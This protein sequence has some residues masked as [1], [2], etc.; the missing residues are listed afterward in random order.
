MKRIAALF[1]L[2]L[3]AA[4]ALADIALVGCSAEVDCN[5]CT[6][7]EVTAPT[8]SDGDLLAIFAGYSNDLV[9]EQV[10]ETGWTVRANGEGSNGSDRT[11]LVETKVAASESGTYTVETT[12][13]GS[14]NSVGR[15]CAFSGVHADVLDQTSVEGPDTQD[16]DEWD[17][18]AITTQTANAWV[19]AFVVGAGGAQNTFTVPSGYTS[20]IAN[21]TANPIMDA[22]RKLVASAGSEDP[23]IY[24]VVSASRDSSGATL[25]LKAA[26]AAVP[27]FTA[28]PTESTNTA[29]TVDFTFTSDTTG[30][31]EW[32]LRNSGTSAYADCD[33]IQ[34]GTGEI[35]GGSEPV[36]ATVADSDTVT[37][38]YPEGDIDFCIDDGAGGQSAVSTLGDV[39]RNP[40]SGCAF[41]EI[42]SSLSATSPFSP[43][44]DSLGDT[45]SGSASIDG[46][47]DTTRF[48]C[49]GDLIDASAGFATDG[50]FV[51]A[52][53]DADSLVMTLETSNATV[54][55]ITTLSLINGDGTNLVIPGPG[56]GDIIEYKLA[57]ANGCD[58]DD[59]DGNTETCVTFDTSW[60]VTVNFDT[61]ETEDFVQ[62]D[63]VLLQDVSDTTPGYAAPL[64]SAFTIS[65]NNPLPVLDTSGFNLLAI[66]GDGTTAMTSQD[67]DAACTHND[68]TPVTELHTDSS[69]PSGLTFSSGTLSGTLAVEDEAGFSFKVLCQADGIWDIANITLFGVDTWTMPDITGDTVTAAEATIITSAPW[70]AESVSIIV[71][72]ECSA[73]VAI[74]NVISQS[75]TATSEIAANAAISAAVSSQTCKRRS[76]Y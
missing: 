26:T 9:T 3:L 21:A 56:A 45:T 66:P 8:H 35:L 74:G 69:V 17:P 34:T 61:G 57:H 64:N 41:A 68:L 52:S 28:G 7:L 36:V 44:T 51:C 54:A 32:S 24:G 39:Q 65:L 43:P 60:D 18:A 75:P 38:T 46:V 72:F 5:A 55:N 30:T 49:P 47:S 33:A 37:F 53:K 50:P 22:A 10:N 25:A 31:V 13:G 70:L 11:F 14:I 20:L 4:P 40:C 63:V 2:L 62:V 15:M 27:T 42:A 76:L 6:S 23:G 12:E 1:F 48:T 16:S 71:S 19:I 58:D 59:G 67:Y 29:T 73:S